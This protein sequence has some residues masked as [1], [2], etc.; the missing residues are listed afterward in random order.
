MGSLFAAR[1]SAVAEVV[2]IGTWP[3]QLAALTK[4]LTLIDASGNKSLH[5]FPATGDLREVPPVDMA[6]ILTKSY[7][8]AR[9]ARQAAVL[10]SRES[11]I[12]LA[13]TL[14][15][16]AGNYERLKAD[17]GANRAFAGVTSQAA[18]I[19]APGVVQDTGPGPVHLGGLPQQLEKVNQLLEIFSRAGF[20]THH[21][22]NIQS[23][24]W[25]K[26]AVNAGINPLTAILGCRN[27]YLTRNKTAR[28]LMFRLALETAAA[29]SAQNIPLPYPDVAQ[30]V[31]DVA[32]ATRA[33]QSSML[34]DVLRN[35]PTEIDAICGEVIRQGKQ[36]GV[37]VPANT[38][39]FNYIKEIEKGLR[40]PGTH[41]N[42]SHIL[43]ALRNS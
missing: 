43:Q 18:G 11:P 22:E 9:A 4:G 12:N 16:G 40:K 41:T 35:S 20:E 27:G 13:L 38:L 14:Q 42:R 6:L 24:I 33:N 7:Q 23:L 29:A 17:L 1:L 5:T 10:L 28:D 37:P 19:V 30:H 36:H 3:E 39:I 34:R 8:T 25:G 2:M 32:Q 26:L 21:S 15:N 31:L